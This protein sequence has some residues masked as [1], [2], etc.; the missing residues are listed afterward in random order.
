M[1]KLVA[2]RAEVGRS[3]GHVCTRAG[4]VRRVAVHCSGAAEHFQ[5]VAVVCS[6]FH[7]ACGHDER[8][9]RLSQFFGR[10]RKAFGSL[11]HFPAVKFLVFGFLDGRGYGHFLA[12][13]S[14]GHFI[15]AR[16]SDTIGHG[17]CGN[18]LF[19]NVQVAVGRIGRNRRNTSFDGFRLCI[20]A[21]KVDVVCTIRAVVCKALGQR[22]AAFCITADGNRTVAGNIGYALP[23]A[24]DLIILGCIDLY[25]TGIPDDQSTLVCLRTGTYGIAAKITQ[26]IDRYFS[27]AVDICL[28]ADRGVFVAGD[29]YVIRTINIDRSQRTVRSAVQFN[30][31]ARRSYTQNA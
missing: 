29:R 13:E 23:S 10:D 1:V 11:G 20:F 27:G 30:I 17:N 16:F 26:R 12:V 8:K 28:I 22:A 31:R 14:R 2:L 9:F 3:H 5:L 7:I 24:D 4:K 18:R 19:F 25:C 15:F 6:Q 21:G